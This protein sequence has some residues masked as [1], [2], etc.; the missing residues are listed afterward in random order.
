MRRNDEVYIH[1][2][3]RAWATWDHCSIYARIQEEEQ[4][5]N[6]AKGKRKKTWTGWKPKT[7][8]QTLEFR[9]KV[10]EK[11]DDTEDELATIQRNIET[12]AGKVA[13]HTKAEREKS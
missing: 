9:K 12:A 13:H 2:D 1:N 4:A 3:V 8:E 6:I 11:N 7:D 5:K 10:M